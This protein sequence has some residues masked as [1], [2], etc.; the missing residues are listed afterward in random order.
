M[1][2]KIEYKF[3]TYNDPKNLLAS[4]R[5][6][7]EVSSMLILFADRPLTAFNLF[8]EAVYANKSDLDL[9]LRSIAGHAFFLGDEGVRCEWLLWNAGTDQVPSGFRPRS[10][11]ASGRTIDLDKNR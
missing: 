7:A 11:R 8:E 9:D 10:T 1:L 4:P 2:T 6:G 5:L 3:Q